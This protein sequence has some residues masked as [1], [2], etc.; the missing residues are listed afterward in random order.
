[1]VCRAADDALGKAGAG[2]PAGR[3]VPFLSPV[4]GRGRGRGDGA[5]LL[6][7]LEPVPSAEAFGLFRGVRGC[8][9]GLVNVLAVT[10]IFNVYLQNLNR[11]SELLNCFPDPSARPLPLRDEIP[12]LQ[13]GKT[14]FNGG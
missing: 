5:G 2:V 8:W 6:L 14:V 11:A 10:L 3:A 13:A 1:M 7:R 4:P 9:A 12:F